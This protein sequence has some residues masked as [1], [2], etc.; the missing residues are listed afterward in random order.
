LPALGLGLQPGLE[1]VKGTLRSNDT[2]SAAVLR[3]H[4]GIPDA[5]SLTAI[6]DALV[7]EELGL[8]P[9]PMTLQRIRT[10][11]LARRAGVEAKGQPPEL[12][13]R[14]AGGVV[15]ARRADKASMT[16]ALGRRWVQEDAEAP[17]ERPAPSVPSAPP[18]ALLD[19]VRETI[20]RVGSDGRYG[21]E[22][23]F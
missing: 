9:G 13:A 6:C 19:V 4:L 14:I 1:Q 15:R 17:D 22:K 16:R 18:E 12:A 11:I 8:P 21:A 7:A 2:I 5:S 10:H 20:P 3:D 23:V